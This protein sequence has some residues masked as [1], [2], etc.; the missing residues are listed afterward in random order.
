L[1]DGGKR[2]E[3]MAQIMH[4]AALVTLTCFISLFNRLANDDI[5]TSLTSDINDG[6]KCVT[7]PASYILSKSYENAN[8]GASTK[9]GRAVTRSKKVCDK[10]GKE[11]TVFSTPETLKGKTWD[12]NYLFRRP[13]GGP[14]QERRGRNQVRFSS[15]RYKENGLRLQIQ[16]A[17]EQGKVKE[18]SFLRKRTGLNLVGQTIL[19]TFFG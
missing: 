5:Y 19:Q 16:E 11:Y 18:T 7:A 13:T 8:K 14:S 15:R 12:S 4:T 10:E 1:T 17:K 9:T 2:L 6:I 3:T